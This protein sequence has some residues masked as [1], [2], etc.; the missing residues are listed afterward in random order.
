VDVFDGL[1]EMG[2]SEDEIRRVRLVDPDRSEL[3]GRLLAPA[4]DEC[5]SFSINDFRQDRKLFTAIRRTV[6]D[7]LSRLGSPRSR[8]AIRT[9]GRLFGT[10]L[11][12]QTRTYKL[13]RTV[14][15][16]GTNSPSKQPLDMGAGFLLIAEKFAKR[17]H[18][19]TRVADA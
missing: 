17:Q 18:A 7:N 13:R 2:L 9:S 15:M 10:Q 8:A 12:V 5:R 14:P 16:A 3:H 11:R 19:A 6:D 1:D 4:M